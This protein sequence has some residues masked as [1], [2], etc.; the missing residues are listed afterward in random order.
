VSPLVLATRNEHKLREFAR[1]LD[2]V[3]VRPLPEGIPSPPETGETFAD[4]AL[5]KARAA[6]RA[7]GQA[8]IADDSGVG[9]EAIG[10]RPGVH[11]ARYWGPGATDER[12][13]AKLQDEVPAGTRL[14]YTCVIALVTGDGETTF[15]GTCDGVMAARRSGERG[16]GYDPVF[17]LPDGRTMADLTD[18]EKDAVSH[19]GVAARRLLEFLRR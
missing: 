11:S 13:L 8:A 17:E 14:R 15:E 9:A 16:F 18:A 1:L 10:W 5:I 7:T 12:N 4:N 2:G 19:R 3:E 6:F